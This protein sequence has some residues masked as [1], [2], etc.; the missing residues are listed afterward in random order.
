MTFKDFDDETTVEVVVNPSSVVEAQ[1]EPIQTVLP[2]TVEH[3]VEL[4]PTTT[5]PTR[6]LIANPQIEK[7][8]TELDQTAVALQAQPETTLDEVR[9]SRA[10]LVKRLGEALIQSRLS[11]SL[12][13]ES[14][15][16]VIISKLEILADGGGMTPEEMVSALQVICDSGDKDLNRLLPAIRQDTPTQPG[17]SVT[18]INVGEQKSKQSLV[19]V[20]E[21]ATLMSRALNDTKPE[22]IDV[23]PTLKKSGSQ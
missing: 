1:S 8:L 16:D 19:H 7:L 2:L 22:I 15:K 9:E 17:V 14:L 10:T 3:V 23:T 6:I 11:S 12:R 5:K 13:M 4:I 20:I 21:A 18:Q